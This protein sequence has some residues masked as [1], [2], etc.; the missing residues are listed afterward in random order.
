MRALW[1][2]AA[3]NPGAFRGIQ[4]AS[5]TRKY[6]GIRY[7][8]LQKASLRDLAITAAGLASDEASPY[9]RPE[10]P[11]R[12]YPSTA[13]SGWNEE[14]IAYWQ[15]DPRKYAP[16]E[17]KPD[18]SPPP[19]EELV[20]ECPHH[21]SLHRTTGAL[22]TEDYAFE[23]LLARTEPL[24]L[25]IEDREAWFTYDTRFP[26]NVITPWEPNT[27]RKLERYNVPPQSLWSQ[28]RARVKAL[29]RRQGWKKQLLHEW[30][31]SRLIVTLLRLARG[32]HTSSDYFP[33]LA[34]PL[35]H[36]CGGNI[37]LLDLSSI[38]HSHILR[39]ELIPQ[40]SEEFEALHIEA[41]LRVFTEIPRP[42]YVQ[43]A[44]GQFYTSVRQMNK[45]L[46]DIL[47]SDFPARNDSEL[48]ASLALIAHN[49]FICSGPPDVQTFNTLIWGFKRALNHERGEVFSELIRHVIWTLTK[50]KTRLNELTCA[51]ILDYY[52]LTGRATS[53]EKFVQQLR[54]I[55]YA[56]MLADPAVIINEASDGRLVRTKRGKVLQKAYPTPLVFSSVILGT[57]HFADLDRALDVYF[58]MKED[59]WGLEAQTL[60]RLLEVCMSESHTDNGARREASWNNALWIW[61]EISSI[62]PRPRLADMAEAYAHM[63]GLSTLFDNTPAWNY[64]LKEVSMISQEARKAGVPIA[65]FDI[66]NI[67]ATA[68]A[69]ASKY[70][71]DGKPAGAPAWSADNLLIA[72]S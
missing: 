54:G 36:L 20:Y 17:E 62:T 3:R 18:F 11:Y 67:L 38:I 66:K 35:Q 56:L 40:N 4:C 26:H 24:V 41:S 6:S 25:R 29:R 12:S 71:K 30:A 72:S 68:E 58:E 19:A 27:G 69:L 31:V 61:G 8:P 46:K 60:T 51:E 52:V 23:E 2:R 44:D 34:P 57:I 59:G 14:A 47:S 45:A 13:F 43:D 7:V 49:L 22:V 53:F 15:T 1:L 63:M 55:G 48:S 64:L 21:P 65:D 16:Y 70:R 33:K 32:L 42:Y 37:D 50:C 28:N 39:L 5:C 9:E 10:N